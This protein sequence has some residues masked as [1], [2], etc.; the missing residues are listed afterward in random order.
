MSESDITA[1]KNVL[2]GEAQTEQDILP[3][4]PR[5]AKNGAHADASALEDNIRKI[6]GVPWVLICAGLLISC[7]MYGLDTTIAADVQGAVIETFQDVPQLPWIGAGFPLGSV[8]V[9]LPYNSLFGKFNMKWLYIAGIV[10][11]QAGS[12]LCGAAPTMNALIVGRVIAGAGGTGIYLG[13]LNH[14]SALCTR[15][16]RHLHLSAQLLLGYWYY[17]GPCCG[18]W[19]FTQ[20]GDMAM[21]ILHQLDNRRRF[22]SRLPLLPTCHST[23]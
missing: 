4:S 12:A 7:L 13:G 6:T 3:S 15:G 20:F 11:F 17:P 16:E 22:L 1:E 10:L 18:W 21:G 8:A 5:P 2:N 19:L 9:I 23:F 14:F